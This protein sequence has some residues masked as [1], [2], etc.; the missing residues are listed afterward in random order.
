MKFESENPY[1]Y[2]ARIEQ[3]RV[4]IPNAFDYKS[5]LYVGAFVG[6]TSFLEFLGDKDVMILEMFPPYAE[7][8]AKRYSHFRVVC[9]D[10]RNVDRLLLENEVDVMIWFH[11]PEHVMCN[12]VAD[13]LGRLEIITKNLIIL[14][15]P[16]GFYEQAS[17]GVNIHGAAH[18]CHLY[19]EDFQRFGYNISVLG[20]KDVPLS[21]LLAWRFL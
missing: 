18:L 4:C 9:D 15:C 12:E 13:I 20:E 5:Y 16:F 19:P 7:G 1:T 2:E 11:G 10:V 8:M 6:R 17:D 21:N 3:M 14:G